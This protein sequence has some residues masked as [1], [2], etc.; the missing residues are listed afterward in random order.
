MRVLRAF[1]IFAMGATALIMWYPQRYPLGIDLGNLVLQTCT[2]SLCTFLW[3]LVRGSRIGADPYFDF[4][5]NFLEIDA[6]MFRR[7]VTRIAEELILLA[8]VLELGQWVLPN[9]AG[10]FGDF[11]INALAVVAVSVPCYVVMAL[12]IRT[13]LGRR[14]VRYFVTI[15]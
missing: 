3:I 9:R 1:A 14:L 15:D 7:N 5:S 13:R 10:K 2:F 12:A 4:R 6:A 11:L 8:A